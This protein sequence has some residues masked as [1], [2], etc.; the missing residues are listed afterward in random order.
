MEKSAHLS[1]LLQPASSND[2]YDRERAATDV[3]TQGYWQISTSQ[4]I[5]GHSNHTVN[6]TQIR[7]SSLLI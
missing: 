7:K 1:G 3:L 2:H 6:H 5:P 4:V